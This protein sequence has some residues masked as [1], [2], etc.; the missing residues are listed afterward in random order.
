M[1]PQKGHG[2]RHLSL[3]PNLDSIFLL[4]NTYK[5]ILIVKILFVQ[6]LILFKIFGIIYIERL[7]KYLYLGIAQLVAHV[8]WDHVAAGSSPATQASNYKLQEIIDTV[9]VSGN[10]KKP[11]IK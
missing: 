11:L 9:C 4:T 7:R 6:N 10:W 1:V 5:K 8:I 3:P 2:V